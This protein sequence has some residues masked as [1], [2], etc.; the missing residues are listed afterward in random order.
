MCLME[1]VSPLFPD[2]HPY[3]HP[4]CLAFTL[5]VHPFCT[6]TRYGNL[7]VSDSTGSRFTLSLSN[8]LYEVHYH[9]MGHYTV[10]DFYEVSS[11]RGVYI[12]TTVNGTALVML[13]HS[14][15]P[16]LLV[17]VEHEDHITKISFSNGAEW[18]RLEVPGACV[19]QP[20]S[21]CWYNLSISLIAHLQSGC[22][23]HIYLRY[24]QLVAPMYNLSTAAG[25]LSIE[26]A[27]GIIIAHGESS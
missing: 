9:P 14:W 26:S 21:P 6:D 5:S 13:P 20:A 23:L 18:Q 24:S 4:C 25:P 11:A 19:S 8:H 27:P 15:W 17:C 22:S 7:Y 2:S 1:K 12:T 16:S 3:P 10:H